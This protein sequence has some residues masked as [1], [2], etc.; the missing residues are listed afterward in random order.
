MS[1]TQ[2]RSFPNSLRAYYRGLLVIFWMVLPNYH[3][4]SKAGE[5]DAPIVSVERQNDRPNIVWIL[6]EDMSANFS[7]YGESVISTPNVDWLASTGTRFDKAFVTAPICSISRSALI[8][9]RYQT[10][11]GAQNH[12]SSVPEHPIILPP[13]VSLLP[14]LFRNAG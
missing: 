4:F 7:C 1:L 14:S 10:S 6:V 9:G 5:S 13:D 3:C 2:T 12:R 11:I 8:T